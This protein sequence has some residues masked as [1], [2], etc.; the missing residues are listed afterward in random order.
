MD[1]EDLLEQIADENARGGG[2]R[3]PARLKAR[4]YSTLI[5]RLAET[6]PLLGLAATR[7]GGAGVCVFEHAWTTLPLSERLDA[8]NLCRVCHARIL[9]ERVNRAPIF[10]PHCPYAAFHH[11][12]R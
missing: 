11:P 2:D 9:G 3:A 6:G 12:K 5:N 8:V 7:T 10:W 4:I 1:T